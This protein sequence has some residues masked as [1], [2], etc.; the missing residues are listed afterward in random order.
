MH[1]TF[2]KEPKRKHKN[3]HSHKTNARFE[4]WTPCWVCAFLNGEDMARGAHEK[5]EIFHNGTAWLRNKCI[6]NGVQVPICMDHHE[7]IHRSGGDL[8]LMIK[9]HWQE[10]LMIENGW[11]IKEFVLEYG[12]N[13]LDE[14]WD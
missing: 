2:F 5:H 6:E 10:K 8:D 13:Y 14:D 9:R 1:Q 7:E 12:K 11:N 3:K 4:E